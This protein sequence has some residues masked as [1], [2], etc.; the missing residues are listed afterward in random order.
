[1]HTS[2]LDKIIVKYTQEIGKTVIDYLNFRWLDLQAHQVNLEWKV[3]RD[4]QE[5]LVPGVHGASV[6]YLG[7]LV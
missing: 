2:I 3:D 1:M 5:S 6:A 4:P 7:D